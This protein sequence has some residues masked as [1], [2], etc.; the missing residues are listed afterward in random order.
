M[1]AAF[2]SYPAM[3]TFIEDNQAKFTKMLNGQR[4]VCMEVYNLNLKK[5]NFYMPLEKANDF[6][7]T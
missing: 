7:L 3:F 6:Y 5:M 1:I 4:T 2:K